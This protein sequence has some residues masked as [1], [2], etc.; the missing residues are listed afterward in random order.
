MNELLKSKKFKAAI[1][2]A[3]ISAFG[4]YFEVEPEAIYSTMAPFI[5]FIGFQGLADFKKHAAPEA[6]THDSSTTNIGQVPS[7]G[8]G[9]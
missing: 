2:A 9:K 5:G 3:L 4:N 8:E 6:V 7:N 1:I